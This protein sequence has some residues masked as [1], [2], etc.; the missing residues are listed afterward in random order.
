MKVGFTNFGTGVTGSLWDFGDGHTSVAAA[1]TN[2][3][4]TPGVY[5]VVLTATDGV[6][7]ETMVRTN[8]IAVYD[9]PVPSFTAGPTSGT[10]PLAVSFTN[11]SVNATSYRWT[12]KSGST[13]SEVNPVFTF[14]SAGSYN[15]ILRASNTGGNVSVSNVVIIN[16][17]AP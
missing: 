14:T 16:V 3:Y 1:P 2:T 9:P 8:Y 15:V 11:L 6:N 12:F 7:S 10:A 4:A 5:S 13:S 17:T